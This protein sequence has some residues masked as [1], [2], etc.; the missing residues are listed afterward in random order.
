[1]VRGVVRGTKVV[2]GSGASL[3]TPVWMGDYTPTEG[4]NVMALTQVGLVLVLGPVSTTQSPLTGTI[5]GTPAGG[6]V[7]VLAGGVTYQATYIG[8]PPAVSTLVELAWQGSS[9]IMLG[10][11]VAAGATVIYPPTDPQPP[12]QVTSGTLNVPITQ[13]GDYATPGGWKPFGLPFMQGTRLGT[14]HSGSYF[15]GSQASMLAGA[16][17]DSIRLRLG[18]RSD[19]GATS[20][21]H[22][23]I[24]T[25]STLPTGADVTRILGP[26]D[27]S[28]PAGFA[29][30]WIGTLPAAAYAP[31]IAG[32]GISITGDPYMAFFSLGQNDPA[33]GLLAID[34]RR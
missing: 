28:I 26:Y 19:G 8:T 15:Y 30:G 34:W 29:G 1:M 25:S 4:D 24:H 3:G 14:V 13:D 16:T 23:Y 2:D 6:R 21:V 27:F 12:I 18:P 5:A 31:L 10:T 32:G 11:T 22:V 17:I 33:A 20:N 7:A 9:P